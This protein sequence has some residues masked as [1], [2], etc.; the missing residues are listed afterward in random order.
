MTDFD[1]VKDPDDD[2]EFGIDFHDEL[3]ARAAP[4]TN[5][6]LGAILYFGEDSGFYY[7]VTTAG[8]TG[9]GYPRD[10]PRTAGQTVDYGSCVLTC[11]HPSSVALTT[12]NSATW[13]VPTGITNASQRISGLIA[14]ITLRGGTQ[15]ADYDVTCRITPSA[16]Q[17]IDKTITI[18]VRSQ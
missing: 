15:G 1:N 4:R 5:Y 9:A 3:V 13:I 7:E 12:L 2:C 16:G 14:F 11:R 10:L 17:P 18:S 8:R 6:A